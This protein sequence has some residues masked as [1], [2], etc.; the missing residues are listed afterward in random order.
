MRLDEGRLLVG[1]MI[2]PYVELRR[3]VYDGG[4]RGWGYDGWGD[5]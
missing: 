3:W 4:E 2:K 1:V 5:K